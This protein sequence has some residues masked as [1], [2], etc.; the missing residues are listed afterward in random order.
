MAYLALVCFIIALIY[1][2]LYYFHRDKSTLL[3]VLGWLLAA[4]GLFGGFRPLLIPSLA[5][6]IVGNIKRVINKGKKLK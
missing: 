6:L 1:L 2:R 3:I 4:V 5:C